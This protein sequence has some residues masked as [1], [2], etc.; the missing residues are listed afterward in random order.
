M[1]HGALF[2]SDNSRGESA[3]SSSRS[4]SR[5]SGSCEVSAGIVQGLNLPRG[6][7][8]TEEQRITTVEEFDFTHDAA[9]MECRAAL[10]ALTQHVMEL[11]G[12]S[13]CLVSVIDSSHQVEVANALLLHAF[14]LPFIPCRLGRRVPDCRRGKVPRP[15]IL[16]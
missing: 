16:Y 12:A 14:S 2:W 8:W 9:T 4:W 6:L 1:L 15:S 11:L 3:S 13:G 10:D 7:T 5:P